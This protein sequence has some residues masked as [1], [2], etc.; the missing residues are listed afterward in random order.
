[1]TGE[2]PVAEA[3]I[4]LADSAGIDVSSLDLLGV[5]TRHCMTLLDIAA[6]GVML[7]DRYGRLQIAATRTASDG[8]ARLFALESDGGPCTES[9]QTQEPVSETD[10][11]AAPTRWPQY[12]VCAQEAGVRAVHAFPLKVQTLTVG[13]LGFASTEP[14]ALSDDD[15]QL[16]RALADLATIGVLQQ[17]SAGRAHK[18]AGQL[19]GALDSRVIIEQAKG[20]LAQRSGLSVDQ[21]FNALRHY[22][23]SNRLR[24][25]ELAQQVVDGTGD[26][27]LILD[28]LSTTAARPTQLSRSA[29][30][31]GPPRPNRP[32]TPR[33]GGSGPP[34][35][36]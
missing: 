15:E 5:V 18:V 20:M 35:G 19:Q 4:E 6:S 32:A 29:R 9:Y 25:A 22:A 17:S 11:G 3:A 34:T 8:M 23:R 13:A 28:S 16:A 10:L 1:M 27:T 24:L 33:R 26:P 31:T 21:A 7:A 14:K 36:H 30:P 2:Q 12:A